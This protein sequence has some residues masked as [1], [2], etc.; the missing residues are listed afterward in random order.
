MA[1][2]EMSLQEYDQLRNDLAVY[3]EIVNAITSPKVSDWDLKWYEEHDNN[4]LTISSNSIMDNLSQKAQ[5][6][7]RTLIQEHTD[8]YIKHHN[9]EGEFKFDP[10]D[11]ACKL[12]NVR[13]LYKK[14]D[15]EE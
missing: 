8:S 10:S 7:L 2:V 1:K 14:E 12:G 13:H 4:Q 15:S 3:E 5:G 11:V 9:I 6:V